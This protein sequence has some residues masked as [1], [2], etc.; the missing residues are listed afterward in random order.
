VPGT[1]DQ[2]DV[3]VR[4]KEKPPARCCSGWGFRASIDSSFRP[5][6][7]RAI[8]SVPAT[9][10][11]ANRFRI[12]QQ[13][14]SFPLP[15]PTT[16]RRSQPRFRRLPPRRNATTLGI[17]N[18]GRARSAGGTLPE[19]PLPSTTPCFSASVRTGQALP[20]PGQPAALPH[21]Q[22]QVGANYIT[23][24]SS[25]GLGSR[26]AGQLHLADEQVHLEARQSG[27][28]RRRPETWST[29]SIPTLT[30]IS[31]RTRATSPSSSAGSLTPVKGTWKAAAVLQD[32]YSG[33]RSVR[34]YRNRVVGLTRLDGSFWGQ[35]ENQR[36]AGAAVP[37]P[38]KHRPVDAIRSFHRR[39]ASLR[40]H[41]KARFSQLRAAAGL[42]FA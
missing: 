1:T 15:I 37:V 23:L 8:F 32:Y 13:V 30:S 27:A 26:L 29:G 17:G 35:S 42:S 9:R 11:P 14:A 4:V 25:A 7:S 41:R 21:F 28:P 2:I 5:P 19:C 31:T 38:G 12:G 33:H 10:G 6:F 22:N 34:G 20:R 24:V 40:L 36:T 39:G 18:Y 16:R 3:T